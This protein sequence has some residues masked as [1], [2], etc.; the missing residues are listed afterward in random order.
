M[1]LKFF[2][3]LLF[4]LHINPLNGGIIPNSDIAKSNL[5]PDPSACG[6][7]VEEKIFGGNRTELDEFPW[8]VLLEYYRSGKKE[9]D[10]GGFLINNRYVVTAAHCIDD[11]LK[12]VRLGEWDLNTNPDCSAV[13]NCAPPVV[14]IPVEE[15]LTYKDNNSDVTSRHDIALIRLK[16]EVVYSDFIKPICLPNTIDEITKSYVGQKLI[17]TGWGKTET[18]KNSN[19][20]LKV[21]VPVKKLSECELGF[22]NAYN[23]DISL[24]EYEICAG[25]EKGKDSCFGDS[26][27]PLMTLR[28][29]KSND[30]RYVAVGVVSNGPAKCGSEN[31]PAVY[32][33]VVKY[34]SWIINNL[35]P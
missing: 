34:V 18:S 6:V 30:P 10:C 21:K 28:R 2:A 15:K 23:I 9:F 19:I 27:G 7:F 24:N 26:G 17:V 5:L 32:V 25:G 4:A 20:K 12:S 14:D 3:V 29:D 1:F 35:K 11:E 31:Q 8:A 16:H 13:D 22:K 33:R